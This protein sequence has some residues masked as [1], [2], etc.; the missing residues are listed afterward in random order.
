M[1]AREHD[2]VIIFDV[3]KSSRC[4]C[5]PRMRSIV[6]ELFVDGQIDIFYVLGEMPIWGFN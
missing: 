4:A 3:D 1:A 2:G 6:K 5:V